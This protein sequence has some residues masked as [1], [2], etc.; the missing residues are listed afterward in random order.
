MQKRTIPPHIGIIMDGNGRWAEMRGLPRFEGHK[1]GVERV[2]E[3]IEAA[4][5]IGVRVL[6]LYAFSIE[7][8]M[9]PEDEVNV[10]MG[11]LE[12]TLKGEFLS[13]MSNGIRFRAIGDRERLPEN[14][15]AVIEL[16]EAETRNNDRLIL[17]CALSYGGRDEII[18]AVKKSLAAA[19]GGEITEETVTAHLDTAGTPDPD[20]IIRTSGEQRLSNFLLWQSAYAEFYFTPTLWPDFTKEEL[21]EAVLEYQMR[22]RRFGKVAD[23]A[24]KCT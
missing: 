4:S 18:R 12:S 3:I 7:N 15:R 17:Q 23:G 1:R 22:D 13:F 11:L 9:R 16:I 2:R 6:S 14:I 21:L 24:L 20:L 10:I 5:G 19:P 8:W